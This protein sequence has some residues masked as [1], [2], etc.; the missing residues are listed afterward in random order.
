[1]PVPF[2]IYREHTTSLYRGS[3][4]WE[5]DPGGLYQQVS[6]GDV[7]FICNGYFVRMFNALLE[8]NDPSNCT[9]FTP[10]PYSRLDLG[11]FVN[12]GRSGFPKGDYCSHY[13]T[14]DRGRMRPDE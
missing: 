8:W 11:P 3:A 14:S 12:V 6:I 5:P 10:E 7:G 2:L 9:L 13:V 4:L 1:M